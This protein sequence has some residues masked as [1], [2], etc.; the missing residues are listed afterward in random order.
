MAIFC[1]SCVAV[2]VNAEKLPILQEIIV[3]LIIH[4][5]LELRNEHQNIQEI[6]LII[7]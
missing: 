6:S 1:L 7:M 2:V 5:R 3:A 4:R